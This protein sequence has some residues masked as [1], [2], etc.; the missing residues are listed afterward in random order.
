M[1]EK[2]LEKKL[3]MYKAM[4]AADPNV[5]ISKL[6]LAA[7]EQEQL[8]TLPAKKKITAYLVSLAL[9]PFG[10]IYA[11]KFYFSGTSDG[12]RAALYCALLT[13]LTIFLSTLFFKAVLSAGN[14]SVQQLQQINPND[15]QSLFQ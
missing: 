4:A 6:M 9:P 14:T 12:K 2:D 15:V 3:E 1:E 13:I 5:D 10:L 8:N 11:I 7:L